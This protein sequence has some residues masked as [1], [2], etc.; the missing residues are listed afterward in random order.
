MKIL[1][2]AS[3]LYPDGGLLNE[4]NSEQLT[5]QEFEARVQDIIRRHDRASRLRNAG[6]RPVHKRRDSRRLGPPANLQK[7]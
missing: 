2:G 4:S 5:A 6:S 3:P 7:N 1:Y